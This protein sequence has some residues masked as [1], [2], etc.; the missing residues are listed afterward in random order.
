MKKKKSLQG[1]KREGAG[2]KPKYGEPTETIAFRVP[3]SKVEP[4]K[5]LVNG[6]LK[7]FELD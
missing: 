5:A 2:R 3:V 4:V 1:G 7:P 6:F